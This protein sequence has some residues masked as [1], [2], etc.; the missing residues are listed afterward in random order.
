MYQILHT[1]SK[2]CVFER[3]PYTGVYMQLA[4]NGWHTGAILSNLQ[5]FPTTLKNAYTQHS[6]CV[7][8]TNQSH[9]AH[10]HT[11]TSTAFHVVR[12]VHT[13]FVNT[14]SRH[15]KDWLTL[16]TEVNMT[17]CDFQVI[18]QVQCD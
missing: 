17:C 10:M 13:H 8:Y 7:S 9:C 16:D 6:V 2:H 11:C 18:W 3:Q 1:P 14:S 4:Q 12:T 15:C 5:P